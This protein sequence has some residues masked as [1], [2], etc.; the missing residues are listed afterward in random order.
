[1]ASVTNWLLGFSARRT[2]TE[3]VRVLDASVVEPAQVT[4]VMPVARLFGAASSS[5]AGG[6]R[7]LGVMAEGGTG[8]GIAVLG[9]EGKAAKSYRSGDLVAPGVTL[10]EVKKDGVVISRAGVAQE[11]R[12]PKAPAT[13]PS[14]IA[15]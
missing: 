5:E 7:A 13:P 9:V 1:M 6:I 4:D 2:P 8:R 3:P 11:L 10:K 15:R 12:I 14:P